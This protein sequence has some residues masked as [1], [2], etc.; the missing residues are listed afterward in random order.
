MQWN[1]LPNRTNIAMFSD[2]FELFSILSNILTHYYIIIY[3]FT[4]WNLKYI[5]TQIMKFDNRKTIYFNV[6]VV[7]TQNSISLK[8]NLPCT[9]NFSSVRGLPKMNHRPWEERERGDSYPFSLFFAISKSAVSLHYTICS[10]RSLHRK[11][12]NAAWSKSSAGMWT[13]GQKTRRTLKC[14]TS[15]PPSDLTK[16][17]PR[18][19]TRVRSGHRVWIGN[20]R[21]SPRERFPNG[22]TA[23]VINHIAVIIIISYIYI[24]RALR[25]ISQIAYAL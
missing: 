20:R 11:D 14:W 25:F 15:S 7:T 3:S 16:Q 21:P 6:K 2:N 9:Q 22:N 1:D 18:G 8:S 19:A 5:R 17:T 12:G 4:Y 13:R 10:I 24:Y 23:A